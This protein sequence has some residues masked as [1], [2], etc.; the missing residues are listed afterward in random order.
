MAAVDLD[1]LLLKLKWEEE[2]AKIPV[3]ARQQ[4]L[5]LTEAQR[6]LTQTSAGTAAGITTLGGA[7]QRTT[8]ATNQFQAGWASNAQILQALQRDAGRAAGAVNQLGG[9]AGGSGR[10]LTLLRSA[11]TGVAIQATGASG[12]VGRLA[13]AFLLFGAGGAI[14]IGA[15]AGLAIIAAGYRLITKDAREATAAHQAFVTQ[16]TALTAKRVPETAAL[17]TAQLALSNARDEL[18]RL[19]ARADLVRQRR[20]VG[21]GRTDEI[22]LDEAKRA[23]TVAEQVVAQLQGPAVAEHAEA[24]KE[25]ARA[26]VDSFL[27]GIQFLPLETQLQVL[28]L[29]RPQFAAR[30]GEAGEAWA[31][32]FGKVAGL[33][34][35]R[36]EFIPTPFVRVRTLAEVAG[37]ELPLGVR[38]PRFLPGGQAQFAAFGTGPGAAVGA[39]AARSAAQAAAEQQH[40]ATALDFTRSVLVRAQTPQ[41]TFNL[42]LQL[43]QRALDEGAISAD[44]FSAGVKQLTEDMQKAKKQTGLL[45]ASIVTAV[46]GAIAAVISGG[47]AGG[48]IS[49]IGGIVGLIPGGQLAGA[50]I[51]GIGTI[52]LAGENRG[53]RIDSYSREALEQLRGIPSGPQRI[54]L[55]IQSPTS[56]EIVDRVIYT[57]GERGRNR[58]VTRVPLVVVGG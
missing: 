9:A 52:A 21:R 4:L 1:E 46:S 18:A 3:G 58:G 31:E 15:A 57:L 34:F 12:P 2:G 28:R 10:G 35:R 25:S 45:A 55:L 38:D 20:L 30:G 23:V 17:R 5:G 6:A 33:L 26:W 49:A 40:Y 56:G 42:G 22:A 13:S 43:L 41:Q 36:P 14:A 19:E 51:G 8:R 50:I 16:L 11:M 53:V 32:A 47:S 39:R 29:A 44:Q 54:E 24:G 7:V 37:G 27:K 48:I